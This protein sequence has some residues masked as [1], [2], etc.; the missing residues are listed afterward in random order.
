M[1]FQSVYVTGGRTAV[2]GGRT[3]RGGRSDRRIEAGRTAIDNEQTDFGRI[4]DLQ[5]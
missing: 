4:Q 5:F 1:P 3:A 2:S